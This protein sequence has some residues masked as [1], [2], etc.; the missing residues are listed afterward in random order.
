MKVSVYLMDHPEFGRKKTIQHSFMS[1]AIASVILF[2]FQLNHILFSLLFVA[3]KFSITLA[4]MVIFSYIQTL[5]PYT[6]ELYPT[7]LRSK[8]MGITS[9]SGRLAT[10]LLG[11]VGVYA[12]ELM[13]GKLLY[14]IF[15]AICL[16]SYFAI[17]AMPYDTLGKDLDHH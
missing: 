3:I 9:L 5:Y 14:L 6:A 13:G 17:N 15:M 10:I 16:I 12:L 4:F 7:L 1:C 8:A 2:L 11:V